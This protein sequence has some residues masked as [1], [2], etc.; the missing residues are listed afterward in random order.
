MILFKFKFYSKAWK[1]FS[2][3]ESIKEDHNDA[4]N[5]PIVSSTSSCGI[6]YCPKVQHLAKSS[7][8][9]NAIP[10]SSSSPYIMESSE[11]TRRLSAA[12]SSLD[13]NN[14]ST[15]VNNGSTSR[16]SA[17]YSSYKLIKN[18]QSSLMPNAN[19]SVIDQ[20]LLLA[21][22]ANLNKQQ[23]NQDDMQSHM[24]MDSKLS[25]QKSQQDSISNRSI[26]NLQNKFTNFNLSQQQLQFK[27]ELDSKLNGTNENGHLIQE[28]NVLNQNIN[29]K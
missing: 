15:N 20:P 21:P 29:L 18:S 23:R 22:V 11:D 13:F 25:Q 17:S 8:Q 12:T 9:K 1:K 28:E 19:K 5:T 26:E 24:H 16:N 10:P 27:K 6:Y 4:E 14:E 2:T 3:N 7:P